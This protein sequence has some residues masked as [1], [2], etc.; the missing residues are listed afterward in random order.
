MSARNIGT[1]WRN[2]GATGSGS[3]RNRDCQG[4]LMHTSATCSSYQS[5]APASDQFFSSD[6]NYGVRDGVISTIAP[7]VFFYWSK[8]TAPRANFTIQIAQART[9]T[10]FPFCEIQ[11]GQIRI[12]DANCNPL[13]EGYETGPGQAAVDVT[14]ATPGAVFIVQ[15]KYSLKNLIG[16]PMPPLTA[17]YRRAPWVSMENSS[18]SPERTA[19]VCHVGTDS[20]LTVTGATA[21]VTATRRS[22]VN[23][24]VGPT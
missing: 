6:V 18:T 23:S 20:P 1:A 19:N 16:T 3:F 10:I 21:P 2:D 11:Q 14:G 24:N 8:I 7:G 5:G 12:Y 13:G 22:S 9:N 4:E 15:V 17:M